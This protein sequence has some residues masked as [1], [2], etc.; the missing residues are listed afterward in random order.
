MTGR[1]IELAGRATLHIVERGDRLGAAVVL[2]HGF[3]DSWRSFERVLPHVA[4]SLHVVAVT[5]RGHGDA[6]R[7]ADG[8]GLPSFSGDVL[9]LLDALR[10][11]R[12]VIVGH[13]MGSAVA[14]RF[15]VDH[16]ERV[17]GLVLISAAAGVRGT[18]AARAHWDHVLANLSDPVPRDFLRES[19]AGDFVVPVP[20][21]V[22]DAMTDESAKVPLRVWRAVLD[23][24]WRADGDYAAELVN[25]RAPTLILWGDRD[26]R[27]P[28]AEQDA[29]LAG[30]RGSRLV[31]FEGAGHML[32][33]EEPERCAREVSAFVHEIGP[34]L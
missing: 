11:E 7:P 32:H 17:R 10:I 34:G 26:P 31:V 28:R 16:P 9:E 19:T 4:P 33:I 27:C 21:A 1:Q 29:L 30:I 22:L 25:L 15:A 18:P 2:L 14:L 12:A 8:Y 3:T 24:R 23:A 5:Q 20:P 6:S 13:S